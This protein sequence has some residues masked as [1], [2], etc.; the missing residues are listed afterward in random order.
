LI[1][2]CSGVYEPE[3][4]SYMLLDALL[5]RDLEGKRVLDM[6]TG[7]GIIA[8]AAAQAGADVTAVDVNPLTWHRGR[9]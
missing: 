8:I 5:S 7:T 3:D 2:P 6:G 9:S 1:Q 4:D